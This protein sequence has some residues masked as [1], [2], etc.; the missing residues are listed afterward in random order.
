MTEE[1]I[2]KESGKQ[3]SERYGLVLAEIGEV[4]QQDRVQA[5]A[6]PCG[7][8]I[9]QLQLMEE[10]WRTPEGAVQLVVCSHTWGR[11]IYPSIIQTGRSG[12]CL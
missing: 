9:S 3:K 7:S 12:T 11:G 10:Q 8:D 4:Y 2:R 5:E 6:F 1:T